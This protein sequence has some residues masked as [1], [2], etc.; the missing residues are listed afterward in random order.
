MLAYNILLWFIIIW[1]MVDVCFRASPR[2]VQRRI[3]GWLM[4]QNRKLEEETE[5]L[6]EK[7]KNTRNKV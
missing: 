5:E 3:I 1:L 6:K 4:E 7:N 2:E